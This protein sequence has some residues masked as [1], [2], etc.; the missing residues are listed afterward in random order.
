MARPEVGADQGA[1]LAETLVALGSV[2]G[3]LVAIGLRDTD[4]EGVDTE[5]DRVNELGRLEPVLNPHAIDERRP[6]K[7]NDAAALLACA[8]ALPLPST[9]ETKGRLHSTP[10]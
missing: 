6:S 9:H 1:K 2:E 4:V 7:R 10:C 5:P 3:G 8:A